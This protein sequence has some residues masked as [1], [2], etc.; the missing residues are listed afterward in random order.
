MYIL[1][2]VLAE[3]KLLSVDILL[4]GDIMKVEAVIWI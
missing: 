1:M 4:Y 2:S 3:T